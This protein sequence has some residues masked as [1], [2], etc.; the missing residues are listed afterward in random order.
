MP[1]DWISQS[2][3]FDLK[4]RDHTRRRKCKTGYSITCKKGMWK[5]F[6]P[7]EEEAEREARRYYLQY[8]EDGEY[9]DA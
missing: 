4:F 7:T 3:L 2:L 8:F 6:A 1:N 9:D 5:V